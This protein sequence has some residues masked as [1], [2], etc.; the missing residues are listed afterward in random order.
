MLHDEPAC[1]KIKRGG[2]FDPMGRGPSQSA[3]RAGQ[4]LRKMRKSALARFVDDGL[5]PLHKEAILPLVGRLRCD[6]AFE[7]NG[8]QVREGDEKFI[9]VHVTVV[10]IVVDHRSRI[11]SVEWK[12]DR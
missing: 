4:G 7:F 9:R 2:V 6:D 5:A 10:I 11:R 1:R 12:G 3:L 8:S